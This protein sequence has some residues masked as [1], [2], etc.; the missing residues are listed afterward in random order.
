MSVCFARLTRVC[1]AD[2]APAYFLSK[3]FMEIP[4]TFVQMLVQYILV[5]FMMD[6][7]GNFILMVL[8]SFA[9]SMVSNS[10]AM[11]LGCLVPDVKDVTELAPL[12]FVPQILFGGF[13]IRTSQIPVFLRWAQYLCGMKYGMNLVL[14][15]EFN[16]SLHSCSSPQ[17]HDNCENVLKNNDIDQDRYWI[18]IILLAALF[19]FFR[20]SAG[21]I[22]VQKAKKFY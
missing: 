4:L 14:L 8:A 16:P 2:K 20:L 17:A 13:F 5:Y 6:F 22:L 19:I 11:A 10:V 3:I 15:I 1:C 18:Y 7:Q 9:L 12:L 21:M